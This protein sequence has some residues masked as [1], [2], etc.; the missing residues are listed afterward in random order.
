MIWRTSLNVRRQQLFANRRLWNVDT[1]DGTGSTVWWVPPTTG[2]SID[3]P[4]RI[5]FAGAG[6]C[7]GVLY[8]LQAGLLAVPVGNSILLATDIE[9]GDA[10][11]L[12]ERFVV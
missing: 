3:K 9:S 10:P 8:S 12:C 1:P 5:C 11:A 7:I 2:F 6:F 4:L